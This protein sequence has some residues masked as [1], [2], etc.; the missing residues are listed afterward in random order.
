MIRKK[1]T[2]ALK[3]VYAWLL[4][5]LFS[6]GTTAKPSADQKNVLIIVVD[7]GGFEYG[8]YGN[9]K[10]NT[11]NVDQLA[12]RSVVFKHAFTSVSSCS[13]SR[14]AILT[15]I[16]TCNACTLAWHIMLYISSTHALLVIAIVHFP[17]KGLP[18]HQNGM[19]GLH[20]SVHHFQSFDN[21]RSLPL[22]LNQTNGKYW[23]GIIGKK[24]VGP[25]EVYPFPFS[26]TDQDGYNLN[27]VGRNIT[28]MNQLVRK[29]LGEAQDKAKPFLLYIGIF[30]VHRGCGA[31]F[32]EHFGDGSKG[33]GVIPDWK[34][35]D[36]TPDDVIVP[37]FLPDTPKTRM[38][39][40][41]QYRTINRMDQGVGLFMKALKDYGFDNNTLIIMT[42]DN[43]IPF[44]N[45][46]TNLYEPGMAEPMIISNPMVPERWGEE[47]EALASTTDIVP[48][49]L[50]WFDMPYPK[51]S[52]NGANPV[53]LTGK[54]LLPVTKEE[55]T[56]G[57][58]TVFSSHN[59]HEV[60]MYYPMRVVRS[61]Q[62]R[63]IHN[64]NFKMPYPIASDLFASPTFQDVLNRTENSIETKWFKSL[65]D[66]YYRSEWELYD[67]EKD[68]LETKNLID[69]SSLTSVITDM[70]EKL[71]D[72]MQVTNDPWLCMPGGEKAGGSKCSTFFNGL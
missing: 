19:Y 58:D 60:T 67:V 26:Y 47:S 31:T 7:D 13:P 6:R 41:A 69:D 40:A 16:T 72:W 68:P 5:L 36:Y 71:K 28:L 39:L 22:I 51:W 12:K 70:K 43:G 8:I 66:Y 33:N 53:E 65:Q 63:L 61:K 57:Y 64:L 42:A 46:K 27:Q 38:D 44:P 35:I 4:L 18:Q 49:V 15:G 56:T 37:P 2:M 3:F 25:E 21:V 29:F 32:C 9:K 10:I 20:H 11:E 34:P 59:F 14:S 17:F 52:L 45:A 48:T 62:Y 54:S 24:H 23:Y 55:P 30:D 50:D 1:L